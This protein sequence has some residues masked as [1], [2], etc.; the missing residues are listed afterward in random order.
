MEDVKFDMQKVSKSGSGVHTM[1]TTHFLENNLPCRRL[2]EIAS[3]LIDGLNIHHRYSMLTDKIHVYHISGPNIGHANDDLLADPLSNFFRD[4]ES[5][6]HGTEDSNVIYR[7]DS[8][9]D[10]T[11]SLAN[12]QDERSRELFAHY[13][14]NAEV[15]LAEQ[16]STTDVKSQWS[17]RGER[18]LELGA[19][20]FSSE[21]T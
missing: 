4:E 5:N 15:F 6:Q 16:I 20:A 7:S 17:V 11:L 18:V 3:L 8:F 21:Y 14:W 19:G 10:I 9:G 13:L 12:P 2:S 1:C